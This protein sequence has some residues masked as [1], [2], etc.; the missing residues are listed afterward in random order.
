MS[1]VKKVVPSLS[2]LKYYQAMNYLGYTKS[3]MRNYRVILN[4]L[5]HMWLESKNMLANKTA[6]T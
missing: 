4:S 5:M 6:F 3:S 2:Y 1:K